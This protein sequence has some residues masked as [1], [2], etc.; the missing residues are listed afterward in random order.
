MIVEEMIKEDENAQGWDL[1]CDNFKQQLSEVILK[2]FSD[3]F[4]LIIYAFH[5]SV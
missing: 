4:F 1:V 2:S 3:Q 5:N